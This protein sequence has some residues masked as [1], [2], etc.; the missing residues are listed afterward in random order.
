MSDRTQDPDWWKAAEW[1]PQG[2]Y[3]GGTAPPPPVTGEP[4]PAPTA[5]ARV[6]SAAVGAAAAGRRG[7]RGWGDDRW[8]DDDM[9]A[10]RR[11]GL[12][13]GAPAAPKR[14]L[15]QRGAFVAVFSAFLLIACFIPYY[16]VGSIAGI[17]LNQPRSFTVVDSVF[18]GWRI[19]LP[20]V[21]VVALGL[22]TTNSVLRV[23]SR[24]AVGIL[25]LLRFV[26]LIQL[27]LWILVMVDRQV[28]SS[29]PVGASLGA[30]PTIALTWVAWAAVAAAVVGLAGS[31]AT[32]TNSSPGT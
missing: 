19:V 27:G 20:M 18:G 15:D 14:A 8:A 24:G 16:R 30:N 21:A 4:P 9:V 13:T 29:G 22:G 5:P 6:S 23:G 1:L 25:S 7:A 2:E 10:V 12:T 32:M 17:P 26:A 11:R 31:F 3:L 28:A